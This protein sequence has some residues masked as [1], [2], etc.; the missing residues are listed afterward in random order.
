MRIGIPSRRAVEELLARPLPFGRRPLPL[1]DTTPDPGLFG[2]RSV[3]WKVMREPLLIL[4]GGRALLMQAANP[5]VA[6]GAIDFS[7]YAADP[8]GRL[9]RTIHWVTMVTFGTRAE[10]EAACGVVN[11][12]HLRVRGAL[13]AAHATAVQAR[14]TAYTALDADLLR[15]VHASFVDTMLVTHD[16]IVGGLSP[17]ERTRFVREWDAVAELMHV[18]PSLLWRTHRALRAYVDDTVARGTALPGAGSRLVSR[19]VLRPP[20]PS[21][22]LRPGWDVVA[23]TTVG[24]LP[25]AVRRA[26][27]I[28]WTP[29]H[30]AAHAAL[31]LSLRRSRPLLPRRLRISPVHDAALARVGGA[32]ADAAD[33]V[34]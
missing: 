33:R 29:A 25:P 31:C 9:L 34:A 24:L 16:A 28:L 19:T 17:A 10:A 14:G 22:W 2:P 1:L 12:M 5:L 30:S 21:P 27:G 26:Y 32:M 18:P 4:G 11:R 20:L 13:P 3:T 15:W 8:F 6:Q 23:F 7:A